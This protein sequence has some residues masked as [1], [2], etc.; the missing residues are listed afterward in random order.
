MKLNQICPIC[1][2]PYE[3]EGVPRPDGEADE[4]C[5]ECYSKIHHFVKISVVLD[6]GTYE[7]TEIEENFLRDAVNIACRKRGC[8]LIKM[9]VSK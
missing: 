2:K 8:E 7:L 5:P 4:P 3:K 9:E 6:Y 1:G